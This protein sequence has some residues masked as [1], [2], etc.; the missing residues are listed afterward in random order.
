MPLTPVT[1]VT[2]PL[3][4]ATHLDK[5]VYDPA[6]IAEQVV[7]TTAT[8]TLTNKTLTTPTINSPAISTPTGITPNDVGAEPALGFTPEN[9]ANKAIANGYASLDANS[10]VV[11]LPIGAAA[12]T[13]GAILQ[14]DGTWVLRQPVDAAGAAI[15][16]AATVDLTAATGNLV[17]ITGTTA[18]S[19]W[20]MNSGQRVKCVADAALPLTYNATTN[21]LNSGAANVTL[22]AGDRFDVYSDGT[23]VRV[24]VHKAT[25][26]PVK[27]LDGLYLYGTAN[28][29]VTVVNTWQDR[30]GL[31]QTGVAPAWLSVNAAAGT[32]TVLESGTYFAAFCHNWYSN[33]ALA[34]NGY[35][36]ISAGVSVAD[37]YSTFHSSITGWTSQ[38]ASI[39]AQLSANDVIK[40]QIY[41]SSLLP[42]SSSVV[43][44][45]VARIK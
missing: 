20:T 44:L 17:H 25:G 36:R 45:M 19:A 9:A 12:A 40:A 10:E 32:V 34:H 16:S 29:S 8:Q 14:A 15:A 22:A 30:T 18:V 24:D 23:T 2:S 27:P 1:E 3:S 26:G 6:G 5:S 11:Q 42:Y 38:N 4:N 21:A 28:Q 31:T 7:G 13:A 41:S 33:G 39:V 37:Q 35:S 43:R